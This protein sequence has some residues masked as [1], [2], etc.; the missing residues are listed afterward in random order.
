MTSLEADAS[1]I[2]SGTLVEFPRL[3]ANV[4]SHRYSKGGRHSGESHVIRGVDADNYVITNMLGV[5]VIDC[6]D[7]TRDLQGIAEHLRNHFNAVVALPKISEFIDICAANGFV[8][9]GTWG[10]GR[11][12]AVPDSARRERLGLYSKVYNADALLDLIIEHRKW[13]LNPITKVLGAILFVAG[14][15]N[16]FMIPV[17]GGLI[18]PLKQLDMSLTDIF[19]LVLPIIFLMELAL[20]E[21]GHAVSCR[22]MGARPK[23]FGLGL[24]WGFMPILFTDTTDAYTIDAKGKRMFVSFAGPMVDIMCFGLV[25]MGYW[26]VSADGLAAKLLLAYSAFPLSSFIISLNPFFI[27]MDGYWILADWLDQPNL[28]RASVRYLKQLFGRG[29]KNTGPEFACADAS[30][31]QRSDR[32]IYLSYIVIASAWTLGYL[33]FVFYSSATTMVALITNFYSGSVFR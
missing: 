30:P 17:G 19:I 26:S 24:L 22:M 32:F 8:E 4:T 14:I 16:L 27:R 7:G 33:V 15:A 28:R 25:M 29:A 3:R 20:H 13:W 2:D 21:I 6:L 11:T 1:P 18:A 5:K 23:G 10:I 9:Q 31:P 12:L